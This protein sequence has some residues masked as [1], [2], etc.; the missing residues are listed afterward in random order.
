VIDS[1]AEGV[2]VADAQGNFV[3]F[4]QAA[5]RMLGLGAAGVPPSE[6]SKHYH[7]HLP[8]EDEPAPTA[9]LPLV[10]ALAGEEVNDVEL[11]ITPSGS[12]ARVP[13]S[14]TARPL[15]TETGSFNGGVVVFR[16]MTH[17][18]RE[19]SNRAARQSSI[20]QADRVRTLGE[21]TA[22]LAHELNQPLCA[23]MNYSNAL[24]RMLEQG[25]FD[26]DSVQ[27]ILSQITTQAHRSGQIMNRIQRLSAQDEHFDLR[28]IDVN[29]VVRD[30]RRL[31]DSEIRAAG[32]RL[33]TVLVEPLPSVRIDEIRIEQVLL[34][35]VRNAV[36]ALR[37][38]P[39]AQRRVVIRTEALETYVR[40]S[41]R[42]Y[43][44]GI[45]AE[46]ES[47]IYEAFFTTKPGG[48][49]MGLPISRTVVEQLGGRLGFIRESPGTT[50]WF[51]IPAAPRKL[52][53]H[54]APDGFCDR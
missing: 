4:N 8:G 16:D 23:I 2:V 14:C 49:G 9:A 34:N 41:V 37:D 43:G 32:V 28:S 20:S 19:E 29:A 33:E 18:R 45:P 21:I 25:T 26:V 1:V 12:S 46:R 30:V 11:E 22:G 48:M 31:L 3:L 27:Q 54:G 10:R 44:I 6:W 42:D 35:I 36:D 38:F 52:H 24:S 5:E 53:S 17:A 47:R 50:F 7:V 40:V 51:T 13:I 39:P 15:R